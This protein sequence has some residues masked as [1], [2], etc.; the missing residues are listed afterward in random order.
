MKIFAT[1]IAQFEEHCLKNK[2][3]DTTDHDIHLV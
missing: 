2:F 1:R 3:Q